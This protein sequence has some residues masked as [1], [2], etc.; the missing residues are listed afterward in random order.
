MTFKIEKSTKMMVPEWL[1]RESSPTAL[2]AA[3][4]T[5]GLG[6]PPKGKGA[7]RLKH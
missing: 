7:M 2:K 3:A 1:R 6:N 4:E 5:G